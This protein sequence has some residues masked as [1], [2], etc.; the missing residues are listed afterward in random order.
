MLECL[1]LGDSIAVGLQQFYQE[2][3]LVGKGG[4]NTSQWNKLYTKNDL[5]ANVVIISLAT[6]DHRFVRT[7]RELIKMRE[8]V[9]ASKVFWI[10]PAGNLQGS[11]VPIQQIRQYVKDV[12]EKYGDTVLPVKK[13]QADGIHPSWAGYKELVNVIKTGN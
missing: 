1:V 8:R 5:S 6:N 13:L 11:G 12:A 2:C 9:Q 7:E 10:L 4:I 3:E